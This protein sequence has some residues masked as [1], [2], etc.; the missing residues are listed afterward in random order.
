MF[1]NGS[2]L[3][4]RRRFKKLD[5]KK[6]LSKKLDKTML[7][8]STSINSSSSNV[9][10]PASDN[11]Q[12]IDNQLDQLTNNSHVNNHPMTNR[13][14]THLNR[15]LDNNIDRNMD[16][17]LDHNL[18]NHLD[19]CLNNSQFQQQQE[20]PALAD[21]TTP[22]DS[23][24]S[25]CLTVANYTIATSKTNASKKLKKLS[26]VKHQQQQQLK[27]AADRYGDRYGKY[28]D[29]FIDKYADQAA[30]KYASSTFDVCNPHENATVANCLQ[31]SFDQEYLLSNLDC[32]SIQSHSLQSSLNSSS[33]QSSSSSQGLLQPANLQSLN[34]NN[35][36]HT[37]L[38]HNSLHGNSLAHPSGHPT[39]K[40]PLTNCSAADSAAAAT[41]LSGGT[42]NSPSSSSLST[43]SSLISATQN[44]AATIDYNVDRNENEQF[45][46]SPSFAQI[47]NQYNPITNSYSYQMQL[48]STHTI[49]QLQNQYHNDFNYNPTSD[50]QYNLEYNY[51]HYSKYNSNNSY[52]PIPE[53]YN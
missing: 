45:T 12:V 18:D 23:S 19:N 14:D 13:I 17:N 51:C 35:Q 50:P 5:Q 21:S 37:N 6:S 20:T 2:Y 9:K 11:Q 44:H 16:H 27:Y 49:N 36:I 30:G 46:Q 53:Y 29:K 43:N 10:A 39:T 40:S 48:P 33:L 8:S 42:T 24:S 41:Y 15:N 52:Q 3:R 26:T 7:V 47:P 4:R 34:H 22:I 28:M 32:Q 38:L 1:V 31:A 25:T